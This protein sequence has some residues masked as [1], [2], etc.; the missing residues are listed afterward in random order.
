M[1]KMKKAA[2]KAISLLTCFVMSITA[3][4]SCDESDDDSS[5][6]NSDTSSITTDD[7]PNSLSDV[8][9]G[10]I[11]DIYSLVCSSVGYELSDVGFQTSAGIAY[12]TEN[13]KY[14]AFGIYYYAEGT[15]NDD[16]RP[17]GFVEISNKPSTAYH[18]E[19][20][21]TLIVVD[22]TDPSNNSIEKICTYNYN[23]IRSSHFVYKNKYVTFRQES[24]MKIVYSEMENDPENYDLDLGSLY[25]YD[26]KKYLY[27]EEIF[28][29]VYETHSSV[30]YFTDNDYKKMAEQF[31]TI[32]EAQEKNGYNVEKVEVVYIDQKNIQAYLDSNENDT[33]FGYDV[34]ELKSSFGE[35][36]VI[37][38][39]DGKFVEVSH[40]YDNLKDYNWKSFL[41]K[42]GI[43]AGII[44]VTAILSPLTGGASFGCALV[45]IAKNSVGSSLIAGL[46]KV[47]EQSVINVINGESIGD[48]VKKSLGEG[49]DTFANT[50]IITSFLF[51][52][53]NTAKNIISN[54]TAAKSGDS[55]T[56]ETTPL[57]DEAAKSKKPNRSDAVSDA[58]KQ[59]R[60]NVL[61][62]TSK[63]KWTRKQKKEL[64]KNGK[65]DG[66]EGH[67][68][69]SVKDCENTNLEHLISDPDNIVFVNRQQH[70]KL[71][72][73]NWKNPTDMDALVE[74]FPWAKNT[75]AK[76]LAK[77]A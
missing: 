22:D 30:G 40:W 60:E 21:E 24:P 46:T 35:G 6:N 45:S 41:T 43:G 53:G 49:L 1:M 8:E 57:I 62:K 56:V 76:L 77:A 16:F 61:N 36:N 47:A 13:D 10:E 17:V 38:Y 32:A 37:E 42:V 20:E 11:D 15:E 59:E 28:S 67:H 33:F 3:L 66:I 75:V 72:S 27:D 50:F 34:N 58:W 51:G 63:Y 9:S 12:T 65:I 5:G 68:I 31:K 39:K 64:I 2:L 4:T 26:N 18:P 69:I 7:T 71:H 25:D 23:N 48:A 19:D 29:G 74:M 55:I 44:I 70:L 52:V 14:K 54:K 73:M